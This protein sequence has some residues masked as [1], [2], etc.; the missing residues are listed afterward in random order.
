MVKQYLY[1]IGYAS[2]IHNNQVDIKR[3]MSTLR[4][5]QVNYLVDVR[6]V[7]FSGQ[8]PQANA[9]YLKAAGKAYSIPYVH[10]PELGAKADAQQDVFSLASDVFFDSDV[11]PIAKSNRPE[12]TELKSSDYIVDFNKFR[13]DDYFISGLERIDVAYEKGFTLCLMCSEK[14][15][16]DCHRY[17]LISK[18]LANRFGER[19]EIRHITIK[20]GQLAFI[21]QPELDEQLKDLV[22]TKRKLNDEILTP[23]WFGESILDK[24]YGDSQQAKLDD[25]CD[26]F[27]NLF[28]GW[29]KGNVNNYD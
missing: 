14:N 8:F 9:D 24:Y 22:C 29:K 27:W 15:P 10:M 26:R 18:S 19:L 12:K 4:D 20:D 16:M 7:P 28:H 13:H 5:C 2:F 17:F 1:T 3:M 6:S 23:Y 11:F 21:T 25:Y